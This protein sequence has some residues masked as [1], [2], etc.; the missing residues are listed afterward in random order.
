MIF[1]WMRE[2]IDHS[3]NVS[4]STFIQ[5]FADFLNREKRESMDNSNLKKT[6]KKKKNL[7]FSQNFNIAITREKTIQPTFHYLP[8]LRPVRSSWE[9]HRAVKQMAQEGKGLIHKL[10]E[11][12]L[13]WA[14]VDS[15]WNWS[16]VSNNITEDW[17][18]GSEVSDYKRLLRPKEN[19]I[20]KITTERAVST[21]SSF[22]WHFHEIICI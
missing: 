20:L 9:W 10:C 8:F 11:Q 22:L 18:L 19:L 14:R 7:H 16:K 4:L 3:R 6:K 15:V 12:L 17:Y 1:C 2:I 5:L 21:P 13:L